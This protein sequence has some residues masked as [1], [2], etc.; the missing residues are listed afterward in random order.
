[1]FKIMPTVVY[2]VNNP[3]PTALNSRSSRAQQGTNTAKYA[4]VAVRSR[5]LKCK[6]LA[7]LQCFFMYCRLSEE[8]TTVNVRGMKMKQ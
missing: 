5:T 1:M 8:A 2:P 7:L 6:A 3:K 4:R